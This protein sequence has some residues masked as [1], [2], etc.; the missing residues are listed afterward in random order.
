MASKDYYEILGVSKTASDDEIKKA[1]RSLAKKYHPDINH[2]PDAPEKFKEVQEAYDCLSD[3]QKR[4][5]YDKYGTADPNQ[6]FGGFGQGFE[7]FSAN[8][9]DLGDIFSSFFGGGRTKTSQGPLKGQ[10]I[11]KRMAVSLEDCIFGKK[12]EIQ[13][14]V[15]ETCTHCHGSGAENESD[16]VSCPKCQGRGTIVQQMQTLFGMSQT[17]RACPDC[18]GTGKYIKNKCKTCSGEGRVKTTKT[19]SVDIP[20]GINSGQQIRFTGFGGK[21]YNGGPNGDLY[22]Q[23]VV[24]DHAR[25]ERDGDNLICEELINFYE[26]ACGITKD[27]ETPYGPEK[28]TIQEGT[29]TGTVLKIKGKGIPNVR[30][31][32]KGDLYV[33]LTVETPKNLSKD[34]KEKLAEIFQAKK[35]S[36]SFFKRK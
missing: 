24:K 25:Y 3:S 7:G 21:G 31:H 1:Y 4:S 18:N 6:G 23:F 27:V 22:I 26:A 36:S 5:N 13:I 19:V 11:Q 14:P 9:E 15:Y 29:Q 32:Q 28:L 30:N 2:D 20:I 16:I 17:R 34:Q 33:K 10:D 8:F 12:T 35:E